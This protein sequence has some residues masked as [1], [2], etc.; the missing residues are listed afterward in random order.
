MACIDNIVQ[1]GLCPEDEGAATS[2]FTLLQAPGMSPTVFA[3]IANENYKSGHQ[4]ALQKKE[5][6]INQVRNDFIGAL[7]NNSVV[8]MMAKPVYDSSKYN[9]GQSTGNYDGERGL[10][11]HK[12]RRHGGLMQTVIKNIQLYP[13]SSG[14]ATIKIYDGYVE[15]QYAVTLVAN[16]VNTFDADYVLDGASVRVLID[17]TDIAFASAPI[18]CHKGCNNQVPNNCAWVDG[19]N[20]TAAVRTEAY[21]INVQ[22]YCECKYDQVIC[23]IKYMGEIIWLKWQ[24]AILEEQLRTKRFTNW[25]IYTADVLPDAIA[26]L[27]RK[28][29]EKW[30]EM[31]N[32]L[33]GVLRTYRDECLDCRGV[34]WKS[35]V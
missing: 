19:W 1:L 18:I 22:F 2:G 33:F 30:N 10:T 23:D 32:G 7:Q 14:S 5:L 15:T 35:N 21:G 34:R 27:N 28:Y 13:L 24:I 3:N 4:L 29:V 8:A 26:D 17:Q 16:Q 9:T 20:G 11:I 25:V 6:A 12:T 31:M